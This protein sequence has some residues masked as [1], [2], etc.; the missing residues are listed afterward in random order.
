MAPGRIKKQSN[1]GGSAGGFGSPHH[2]RKGQVARARAQS[3]RR[4]RRQM[5]ASTCS[6]SCVSLTAL[7]CSENAVFG[8]HCLV[9]ISAWTFW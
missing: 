4:P 7:H 5:G 8:T 1:Q 3:N 2:T 6:G 9:M